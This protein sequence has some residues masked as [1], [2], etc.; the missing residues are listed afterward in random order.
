MGS[1]QPDWESVCINMILDRTT[2]PKIVYGDAFDRHLVQIYNLRLTHPNEEIY[3]FDDDAK[4]VC[5]RPKY[6]P[7]VASAFVF[8]I[9]SYLMIPLRFTFGSSVSPQD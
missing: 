7:D 9:S 1:F 2:D 5:R 3:L 4:E 8:R 6:H